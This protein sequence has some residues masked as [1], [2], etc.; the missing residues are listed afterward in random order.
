MK[1]SLFWPCGVISLL[2]TNS[3]N[4]SDF[5]TGAVV[6][7]FVFVFESKIEDVDESIEEA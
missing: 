7:V 1:D 3:L 4:R 2:F 5:C 6:F